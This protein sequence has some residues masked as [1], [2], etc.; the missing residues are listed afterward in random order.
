MNQ[1]K[2][3]VL[4]ILD[5]WGL[6]TKPEVDALK[7]ADT[8]FMDDL[9]LNRPNSTLITFGE[10]VGLPEGQMGNSEVGHMN[11]GTGRI[12]KQDLPK[13][14]QAV[15]EKLTSVLYRNHKYCPS[16]IMMSA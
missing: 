6:G 14:N 8:P 11:I 1:L 12:I 15:A 13:I 3:A 9:L 4:V 16:T 10:E 5:G 2:R 7:Q